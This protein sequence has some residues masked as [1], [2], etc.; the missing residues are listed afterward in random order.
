MNYKYFEN[1]YSSFLGRR[2]CMEHDITLALQYYHELLKVRTDNS[3]KGDFVNRGL[4]ICCANPRN[5][6]LIT[7][8]NPSGVSKDTLF[9]T[10]RETMSIPERRC[11]SYWRNKYDQ[12]IGDDDYLL[13][14]TAYLDLFPFVESSQNKFSKEIEGN[15][16]FQ[17]Q[18]MLI[19]FAEIEKHI[20]P[21]LI[22]ASNSRSS[23]YWGIKRKYPW[24]GY[25]LERVKEMPPCLKGQDIRLYQIKSDTGFSNHENRVKQNIEFAPDFRESSLNRK[26]FI[27]YAMYDE[28]HRK[29]CSQRFL[30]PQI[31]RDLY[32]WIEQNDT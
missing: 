30:T 13:N 3:I 25:A 1:L 23:F 20:C 8:I 21:K 4:S 5:G 2:D 12:L 9:Y 26:Y 15:V 32:N 22:I 27:D 11:N 29:K 19:T 16:E 6:I 17:K 24:M 18:I 28:R 31:V 7:G 14:H 10:F